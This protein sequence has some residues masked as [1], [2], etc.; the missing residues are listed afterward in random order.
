M[1]ATIV[2]VDDGLNKQHPLLLPT[3]ELAITKLIVITIEQPAVAADMHIISDEICFGSPTWLSA[4]STLVKLFTNT[5]V[6][7]GFTIGLAEQ[8][9]ITPNG[10]ITT[11]QINRGFNCS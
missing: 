3:S 4:T 8:A 7:T 10:N 2:Y 5:Q 1:K 11:H 6:V 9:T